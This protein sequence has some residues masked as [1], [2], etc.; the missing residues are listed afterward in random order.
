ML[1]RSI[2][3]C[4]E[5]LL[6]Q[7]LLYTEYEIICIDDYSKDSTIDII[8]SYKSQYPNIILIRHN[9]NRSIGE[10]R[11]LGL[12]IAKGEYVWFIDP[13]DLIKNNVLLNVYE[14]CKMNSIDVLFFNNVCVKENLEYYKTENIFTNT[15]VYSGQDFVSKYFVNKMDYLCVVWRCI[16]SNKFLCSNQILFPQINKAEDVV[17]VW[18]TILKAKTVNSIDS[19]LYIYRINPYSI[20]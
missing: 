12:K 7:D 10:T 4:L 18:K 15:D 19:I 13:D 8:Y 17:F 14:L 20:G 3:Y 9:E 11:N 5:S 6:N 16:F 2:S 1:F